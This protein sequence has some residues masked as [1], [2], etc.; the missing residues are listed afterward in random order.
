MPRD[1]SIPDKD[2][3]M[4][5]IPRKEPSSANE[6]LGIQLTLTGNQDKQKKVLKQK[7]EIFATQINK[8]RCNKNSA[9]ETFECSFMPSLSYCMAIIQFSKN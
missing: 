2:G 8:K 6:S 9:L 5:T 7:S 1:I 3:T 4:I